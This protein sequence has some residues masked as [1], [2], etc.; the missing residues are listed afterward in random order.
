MRLYHIIYRRRANTAH[1]SRSNEDSSD[2]NY[3]NNRT[4]AI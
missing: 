4:C 3:L 1:A 2:L